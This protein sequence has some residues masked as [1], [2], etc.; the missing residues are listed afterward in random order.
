M[1]EAS[2]TLYSRLGDLY[3]TKQRYQDGANTYRAFVARDPYSDHAPDLA[4]AAIE[5]PTL[6]ARPASSSSAAIRVMVMSPPPFL[7]S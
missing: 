4:M 1:V 3:V 2:F 7:L 5:A 6:T